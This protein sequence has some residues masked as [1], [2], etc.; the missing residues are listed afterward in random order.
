MRGNDDSFGGI[1]RLHDARSTGEAM[2]AMPRS[3]RPATA[4][5]PGA[6]RAAKA[7]HTGSG[8]TDA[9]G[10]PATSPRKEAARMWIAI[11]VTVLVTTFLVVFSMNFHRPEKAVRH[12]V[13]HQ[14]IRK[15]PHKERSIIT[16]L[17]DKIDAMRS[18]ANVLGFTYEEYIME[19]EGFVKFIFHLSD[20][21]KLQLIKSTPV[22]IYAFR[23]QI[24]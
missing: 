4:V 21:E 5:V 19:P 1:H 20:K 23:I 18:I 3:P 7:D 2:T 15:M 12:H 10:G 8:F 6:M 16:V 17:P 24:G 22:D 9:F 14:G 13:R 11:L